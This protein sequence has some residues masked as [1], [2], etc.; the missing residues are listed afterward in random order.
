MRC[1]VSTEDGLVC[2]FIYLAVLGLGCSTWDLHCIIGDLSFWGMNCLVVAYGLSCS[3][4]CRI[5]VPQLG[6]KPA[7]PVLQGGF[8]TTRPPGSPKIC[9]YTSVFR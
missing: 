2:V 7:S 4:A 3:V 9:F 1:S 6:I 8:L 5:L